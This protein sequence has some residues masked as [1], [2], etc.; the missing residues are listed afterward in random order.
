MSTVFKKKVK[1]SGRTRLKPRQRPIAGCG[2]DARLLQQEYKCMQDKS[3]DFS[4]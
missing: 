1:K 2:G 3:I 4:L